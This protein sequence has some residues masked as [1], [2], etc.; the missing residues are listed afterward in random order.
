MRLMALFGLRKGFEDEMPELVLCWDEYCIDENLE[1][2]DKARQEVE[3][4]GEWAKLLLVDIGVNEHK[5]TA[6]MKAVPQLEAWTKQAMSPE[7]Q[8]LLDAWPHRC[9]ECGA[10]ALVKGVDENKNEEVLVCDQ[11]HGHLLSSADAPW[12]AS[13]RRV[14]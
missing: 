9:I 1:G 5:L 7:G 4:S 10:P 8:A 13:L 2:W 12:A 3:K 14:R 11:H 6:M